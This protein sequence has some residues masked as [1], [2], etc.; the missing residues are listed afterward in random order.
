MIAAIYPRKCTEQPSASDPERVDIYVDDGVSGTE[1][2]S[3]PAS[4]A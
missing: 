2:W 1:F 3:G 4:S